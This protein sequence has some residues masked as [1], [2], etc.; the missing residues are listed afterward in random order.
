[1]RLRARASG[2]RGAAA[3][4]A[5]MQDGLDVLAEIALRER[6]QGVAL[7]PVELENENAARDG[8]LV[9]GNGRSRDLD[10]RFDAASRRRAR[11]QGRY[12]VTQAE[13]V[14][15]GEALRGI[16]ADRRRRRRTRRQREARRAKHRAPDASSPLIGHRHARRYITMPR[17][18]RS[19]AAA[20]RLD[21]AWRKN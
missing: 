9:E 10:R 21:G 4:G 1:M 6:A 14:E 19:V 17:R 13:P 7:E 11:R 16:L 12:L 5:E 20:E 2:M 8:R 15:L 18:D 3:I